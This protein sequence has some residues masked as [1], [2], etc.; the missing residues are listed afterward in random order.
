M[1]L[2]KNWARKTLDQKNETDYQPTSQYLIGQF[3]PYNRPSMIVG[4]VIHLKNI[5]S[6][7]GRKRKPEPGINTTKTLKNLKT[8]ATQ[9]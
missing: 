7:K 8:V 5:N 1:N 6:K 4:I 3:H 9:N 2:K